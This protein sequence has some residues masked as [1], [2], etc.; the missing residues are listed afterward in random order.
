MRPAITIIIAIKTTTIPFLDRNRIVYE[1]STLH[2][3]DL[4]KINPILQQNQCNHFNQE[5]YSPQG[6]YGSVWVIIYAKRLPTEAIAQAGVYNSPTE[7]NQDYTI[8]D[9]C[10]AILIPAPYVLT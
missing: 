9:G 2:I 5:N 3:K 10:I 8:A 6:G 7:P 1:K 4:K